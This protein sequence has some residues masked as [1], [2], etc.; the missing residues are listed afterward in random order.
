M[1]RSVFSVQYYI[2]NAHVIIGAS[3]YNDSASHTNTIFVPNHILFIDWFF[4][5]CIYESRD[6]II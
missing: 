1:S 5:Y 6:E 3:A 2:I 4:F